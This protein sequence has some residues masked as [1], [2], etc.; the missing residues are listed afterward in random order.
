MDAPTEM[1]R[2]S[3]RQESR[4]GTC[5]SW[6]QAPK[7]FRAAGNGANANKE[8][9]VAVDLEP[10]VALAGFLTRPQAELQIGAIRDYRNLL[11][12]VNDRLRERHRRRAQ[13]RDHAGGSPRGTARVNNISSGA[14][15]CSGCINGEATRWGIAA[16][17]ERIAGEGWLQKLLSASAHSSA[18]SDR[19]V[20]SGTSAALDD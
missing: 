8:A 9:G 10:A 20:G 4:F 17:A 19:G 18:R 12:R 13:R 3:E 1:A 6:T 2:A 16:G 15:S 7:R 11:L 5:A 14:A